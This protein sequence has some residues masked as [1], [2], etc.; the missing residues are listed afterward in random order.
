MFSLVGSAAGEKENTDMTK[1]KINVAYDLRSFGLA[2]FDEDGE[3]LRLGYEAIVGDLEHTAACA[4]AKACAVGLDI[5]GNYFWETEA[6][7]KRARAVCR[8]AAKHAHGTV[9]PEWTI[10][11]LAAGWKAPKG[12]KP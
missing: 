6:A 10:A 8:A 11:A 9:M 3:G 12:W 7:A 5:H 2:W 1:P 4:A